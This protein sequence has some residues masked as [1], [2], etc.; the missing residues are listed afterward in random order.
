MAATALVFDGAGASEADLATARAAIGRAQL[1][2]IDSDA[3][4]PEVEDLLQGLQ[5]HPLTVEDIFETGTIPKVEQFAGYL[6]VRAHGIALPPRRPQDLRKEELDIVIGDRW[7]FTHRGPQTQA[8]G[9]VRE[10]VLRAGQTLDAT[11]L[12]H[13][14]LDRLVDDSLPA[15]DAIDEAVEKLEKASL[16]RVPRRNLVPQV[17]ALRGALHRFRRTAVHQR[18]ILLR[19][20]RGE[21]SRIPAEQLPFFRDVYDHASRLA[22]LADDARDMLAAVLEA[23]LSMVSNR[24]NEVTKVLTM[25]ATVF[26]PLSFIA[27]VY[28]MNFEFMPELH[29][30][31]G[32]PVVL[33]TMAVTALGLLWWFRRRGWMD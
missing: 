17:M 13:L 11:R 1:I 27:S 22:D 9:G 30:R 3:R 12:A 23:H 31:W 29:W 32:Y 5:L 18:E 21:F 6:Y 2:W 25:T 15:M 4:S 14:L 8:C 10:Q 20:A 24:L 7:L 26:L 16:E 19:L 33:A 28:G